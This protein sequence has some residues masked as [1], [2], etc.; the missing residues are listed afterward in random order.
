MAQQGRL[1]MQQL[2]DLSDELAT[3]IKQQSDARLTEVFIRMNE[4]EI[5]AFDL[6]KARISPSEG[7]SHRT[8]PISCR[9]AVF[10]RIRPFFIAKADIGSVSVPIIHL[11]PATVELASM[12]CKTHIAKRPK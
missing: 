3:L 9:P 1:N 12:L 11:R 4:Q 8:V 5:K 10:S 2:K 7:A 6:R